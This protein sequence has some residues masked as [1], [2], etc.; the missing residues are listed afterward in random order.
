MALLTQLLAAITKASASQSWSE[1]QNEVVSTVLVPLMGEFAKARDLTGFVRHWFAQLV[2]YEKRRKNVEIDAWSAWEDEALQV[3]L[4]KRL[5]ATLTIPQI[6]QILDWLAEE[7]KEHPDA[8]CVILEAIARSVSGEE[9]VV[10]AI[11]L[12]LYH[13]MFDNGVANKLTSRYK[14]RSWNIISYSLRWM[15]YWDVE[16]LALEWDKGARPFRALSS[17][18]AA[19]SVLGKSAKQSS[20]LES[21]EVFRFSCTAWNAAKKERKNKM[22]ELGQPMLLNML[23]GSVRDVRQLLADLQGDVELGNEVCDSKVSTL[24]RGK[25]WLVWSLARCLFVEHPEVLM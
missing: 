11:G 3:E 18:A 16:K 1:I 20:T 25:G 24:E 8:V 21:L 12:R 4:G 22:Q 15:E 7:V 5:E 9:S 2:E 6:I 10:D 17:F 23:H 14:W 19:K 13:I